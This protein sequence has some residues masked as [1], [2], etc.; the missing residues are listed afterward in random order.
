MN[1]KAKIEELKEDIAPFS[2]RLLTIAYNVFKHLYNRDPT[3]EEFKRLQGECEGLF[4]GI[5][6]RLDELENQV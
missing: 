3:V 4:L 1:I 5:F 2:E 6:L